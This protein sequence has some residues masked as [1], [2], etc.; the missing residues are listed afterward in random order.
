MNRLTGVLMGIRTRIA[1]NRPPADPSMIGDI[2][3]YL[4]RSGWVVQSVDAVIPD[5]PRW[6]KRFRSRGVTT[7]PQ[8]GAWSSWSPA[9]SRAH[10]ELNLS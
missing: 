6:E 7:I 4:R 1:G 2:V 5:L 10:N 8:L 9:A 3:N